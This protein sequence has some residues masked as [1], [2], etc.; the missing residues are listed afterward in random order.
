MNTSAERIRDAVARDEEGIEQEEEEAEEQEGEHEPPPGA[1]DPAQNPNEPETEPE[2]AAEPPPL[3]AEQAAKLDKAA[4]TYIRAV[5]RVFGAGN[6]P[7]QCPHCQGLGFDLTGGEPE[8]VLLG[9]ENF[10]GCDECDGYGIVRTGSKVQGHDLH[11]CPKC[12]GRGFLE[13]LPGPVAV[14]EQGEPSYGTPAW[15]GNVD[16]STVA[17]PS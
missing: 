5:E 17:P 2:Q 1:T 12:V 14:P 3:E 11:A 13:R 6:V 8:P 16:G 4:T 10:I 15:M 7:P 9:H